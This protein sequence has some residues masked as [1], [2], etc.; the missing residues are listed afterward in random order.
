[1]IGAKHQPF[2][3]GFTDTLYCLSLWTDELCDAARCFSYARLI[4]FRRRS[5][6]PN[7]LTT[8]WMVRAKHYFPVAVVFTDTRY[9]ITMR[10]GKF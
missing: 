1:M 4:G 9:G 2:T 3:L 10:T 7:I 5:T 8:R 6:M